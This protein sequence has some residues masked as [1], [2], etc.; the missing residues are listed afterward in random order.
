MIVGQ[1]KSIETSDLFLFACKARRSLRDGD[2]MSFTSPGEG[3]LFFEG[4]V[5][6]F[7]QRILVASESIICL[8]CL[9]RRIHD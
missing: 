3:F 9:S 5:F 2:F 7:P 8:C 1:I 6:E 4:P